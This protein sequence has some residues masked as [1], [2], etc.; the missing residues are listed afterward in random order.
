[1]TIADA[2]NRAERTKPGETETAEKLLQL[3][4]LEGR[5]LAEVLV[6]YEGELPEMPD[7]SANDISQELQASGPYEGLYVHYLLMQAAQLLEDYETYENERSLFE[8]LYS[9]WRNEWNRT[10]VHKQVS[11]VYKQ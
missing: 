5:I 9:G 8:S 7:F 6:H 4:A 3:A 2:I 11:K 1:M 10:H